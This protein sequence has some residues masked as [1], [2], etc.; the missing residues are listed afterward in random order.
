M[1]TKTYTIY[2]FDELSESAKECARDWYR[3]GA[4]DYEWWDFVYDDAARI[5][6][7]I[8]A[9]DVDRG[10]IEA[11]LTTSVSEC[12]QRILKEH[13]APCDTYKLAQDYYARKHAGNP[14]DEKEF[15]HALGEE[16]LSILRK[17]CE[18]LLSD[19]CVEESTRANEYTF[20]ENGNR[21]D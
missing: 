3:E 6:L 5:G 10:T 8:S 2:Q 21:E 11:E 12:V 13:G 15:E 9:F 1:E 4:L 17:E 14:Y 20:D 18:Y 16:Y 19:Q 7:K